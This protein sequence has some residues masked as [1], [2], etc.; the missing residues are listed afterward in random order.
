MYGN[1]TEFSG[2]MAITATPPDNHQAPTVAANVR[3][4]H[5]CAL[6]LSKRAR[7]P[8]QAQGTNPSIQQITD[9]AIR[10]Q[11][12]VAGQD[13]HAVVDDCQASRQKINKTTLLGTGE[14]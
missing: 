11:P 7:A 1:S 3:R 13:Q 14:Q 6:S 4:G 10:E 9:H 12:A 2:N 5:R 8:R